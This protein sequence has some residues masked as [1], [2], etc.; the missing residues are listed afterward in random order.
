MKYTIIDSKKKTQFIQQSYDSIEEANKRLQEL[1]NKFN[2]RLTLDES[3]SSC[4]RLSV[5]GVDDKGAFQELASAE[6]KKPVNK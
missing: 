4:L 2:H 6:T 5:V 1:G 3:N